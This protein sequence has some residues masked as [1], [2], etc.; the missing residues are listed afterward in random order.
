MGEKNEDTTE[1]DCGSFYTQTRSV[2]INSILNND[3]C[4][5]RNIPAPDR[6]PAETQICLECQAAARI[7]KVPYAE[8]GHQET[9]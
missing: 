4:A 8:I 2:K 6:G 7:C 1:E 9:K 5:S 3:P